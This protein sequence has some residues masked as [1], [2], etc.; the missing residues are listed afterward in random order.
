MSSLAA[1]FLLVGSTLLLWLLLA[2][3]A[4][5][6]KLRRD[7]RELRSTGRR[8]RY[9]ATLRDGD[10]DAVVTINREARDVEAQVDLAAAIDAVHESLPSARVAELGHAAQESGLLATLIA[11]LDA[12]N[13]VTRA[14]AALL[15]TRTGIPTVIDRITPL[16][17]DEDA[18]VRLVACSGLARIGTAAAAEALIWGLV[19]R[20]LPPERII[21]RLAAPWAVDMILRTIEL[22]PRPVPAALANVTPRGRAVDLNASLARALGVARDPGGEIA[23]QTLLRSGSEEAQVSA[24]RALGRVGGPG[25]VPA[26]VKALDSEVW[27]VRAQAAKSLGLLGATAAIEPLERCL[28]DRAWWVRGNSAR[29]LRELGPPGIEALQRAA[30]HED[31]YARDRAREQL[32]LHM[33]AEE[34]GA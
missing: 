15:L 28:P 33:V 25:C 8:A 30:H 19:T 11:E 12:G 22:G 5:V 29:A 10:H 3:L 32:A 1:L 13:P 16:L 31:A 4:V 14:R 21:E 7:R 2:T 9:E 23:L 18:D 27:P 24:A 34:L 20:A 6:R 26:L 17:G